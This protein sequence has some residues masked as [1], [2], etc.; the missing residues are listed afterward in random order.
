MISAKPSPDYYD[1]TR[2]YHPITTQSL[3]QY[4]AKS[5][6]LQHEFY[7]IATR[8]LWHCNT[9][10]MALQHEFC[11]IMKRKSGHTTVNGM[12]ALYYKEDNSR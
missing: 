5:M 7:G 4:S 6:A 3:R 9:N 11:D 10:S 1:I 8:I 2:H 12:P